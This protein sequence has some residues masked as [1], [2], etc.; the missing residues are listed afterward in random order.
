MLKLVEERKKIIEM[1]KKANPELAHKK[2]TK[3]QGEPSEWLKERLEG[4][5][6]NEMIQAANAD[7]VSKS[8][9]NILPSTNDA[10]KEV[11]PIIQS[12]I[13]L[14]SDINK[15]LYNS[16]NND[17]QILPL[18]NLPFSLPPNFQGTIMIQPTI[19]IQA[20]G[21]YIR[22]DV[23]KY[24]QIMPKGGQVPPAVPIKKRKR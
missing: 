21:N 4:F 5:D 22:N 11:N 3:R 9:T 17:K 20:N 2:F 10:E 13:I 15:I 12:P 19:H 18:N 6:L 1:Q 8:Q 7:S 24:R 23:T 16:T 14:A